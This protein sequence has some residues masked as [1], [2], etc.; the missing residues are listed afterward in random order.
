MRYF[1]TP[2]EAFAGSGRGR[3]DVL[4][5]DRSPDGRYIAA[6]LRVRDT[7]YLLDALYVLE[8]EG[9]IDYSISSGGGVVWSSLDADDPRNIGVLRMTRNAPSDSTAAL[10]GWKDEDYVVPVANGLLYFVRWD[11][12]DA[13][14]LNDADPPFEVVAFR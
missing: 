10:V 5:Q 3:Y 4:A 7:R 6:L 9:W 2:E 1:A 12:A 13:D 11:A 14:V 8:P